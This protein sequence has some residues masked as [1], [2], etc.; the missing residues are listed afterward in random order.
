MVW[1]VPII[2]S[3]NYDFYEYVKFGAIWLKIDIL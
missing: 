3:Q 2:L 1:K